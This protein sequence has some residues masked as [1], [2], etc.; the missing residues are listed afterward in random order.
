MSL[1]YPLAV[2]AQAVRSASI[3]KSRLIG[4]AS[5]LVE[6]RQL[7]LHSTRVTEDCTGRL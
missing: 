7:N 3:M 4:T 6:S 5:R 2:F 1:E